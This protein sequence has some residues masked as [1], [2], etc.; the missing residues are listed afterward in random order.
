MQIR[1]LQ[2]VSLPVLF[3]SRVRGTVL[4]MLFKY[5]H[6]SNIYVYIY[7]MCVCVLLHTD[8][9]SVCDYMH[10]VSG[11]FPWVLHY[12]L[13][14]LAIFYDQVQW[15]NIIKNICNLP[16][17]LVINLRVQFSSIFISSL[18][19]LC[20]KVMYFNHINSSLFFFIP[21]NLILSSYSFTFS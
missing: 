9:W 2:T 18:T 21:L 19:T 6:I 13:L 12:Y 15:V 3:Y 20:M 17:Y 11:P 14:W 8:A 10:C 7:S 1:P 16:W 5:A 4:N